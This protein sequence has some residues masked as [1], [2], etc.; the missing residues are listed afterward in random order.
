M[1]DDG[2]R[3]G[4]Q[5][6]RQSSNALRHSA[7]ASTLG[8]PASSGIGLDTQIC[9]LNWH[10]GRQLVLSATGA[11]ALPACGVVAGAGV[12]AVFGGV[13]AVGDAAFVEPGSA[14]GVGWGSA[15]GRGVSRFRGAATGSTSVGLMGCTA[16]DGSGGGKARPAC[17]SVRPSLHEADRSAEAPPMMTTRATRDMP[18]PDDTP[19]TGEPSRGANPP[20]GTTWRG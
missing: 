4:V 16:A 12:A 2:A 14:A 10:F 11:P 5:A 6:V 13:A 8:A 9:R 1:S 18:N 20:R 19:S 7:R 3:Y 15:R 17:S